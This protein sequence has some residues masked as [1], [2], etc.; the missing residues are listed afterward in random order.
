MIQDHLLSIVIVNWNTLETTKKCLNSITKYLTAP[1]EIILVDNGSQDG[2]VEYFKTLSDQRF[3]V[4]LLNSNRGYSAGNNAGIAE[5]KGDMVRLLNSDAF[6]T[7]GSLEGLIEC[8][9]S[10]HAGMVG[11]LTNRAN[12]KQGRRKYYRLIPIG[13]KV[14]STD[15]LSFFCVLISRSVIDSV[16]YLDERFGLGTYED[17]DYCKRARV[18]GFNLNIYKPS[19]VWHESHATMKANGINEKS[20]LMQ[21]KKIYLA[22]GCGP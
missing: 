20:L 3:K 10:T 1:Y 12:G 22:K 7:K 15:Y 4:I 11:P 21:N 14:I 2:S 17:D 8:M 18:E 16:G 9:I 5:S 19:W 13:R 6:I